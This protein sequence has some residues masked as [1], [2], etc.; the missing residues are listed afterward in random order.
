MLKVERCEF[1]KTILK[2]ENHLEPD[3]IVILQDQDGKLVIGLV[4]SGNY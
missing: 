1:V 3:T 2:Q 4:V